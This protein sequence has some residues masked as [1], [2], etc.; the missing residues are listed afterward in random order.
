MIGSFCRISRDTFSDRSLESTTPLMKRRYSGRNDSAWSMMNTRCTYSFRPRG[1]SRWYRS[2][3][4]RAGTYSSELYSS[5]PSTLL[6]LQASGF[7][8]SW[9]MCL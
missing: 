7:S 6:W 1:A 9:P 2:N 5:L 8:K 3:G 4:A